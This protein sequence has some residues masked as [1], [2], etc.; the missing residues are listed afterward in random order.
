MY[1]NF[2]VFFLK[3]NMNNMY[4]YKRSKLCRNKQDK[5]D[6]VRQLA[7][8]RAKLYNVIKRFTVMRHC[9]VMTVKGREGK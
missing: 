1:I 7:E 6:K 2:H 4:L 5:Q 9:S 3:I 8:I